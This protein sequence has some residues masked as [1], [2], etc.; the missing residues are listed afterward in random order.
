MLVP[1]PVPFFATGCFNADGRDECNFE[2]ESRLYGA[3]KHDE[4]TGSIGDGA[5]LCDGNIYGS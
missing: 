4:Y 5:T 3:L 1:V 2:L